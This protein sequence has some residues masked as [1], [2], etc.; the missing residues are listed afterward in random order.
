MKLKV[1]LSFVLAGALLLTAVPSAGASSN[2]A[3]EDLSKTGTTYE[4]IDVHILF[5][6]TK[7]GLMPGLKTLR[8]K[9]RN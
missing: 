9:S 4:Y 1:F 5:S 6:S 2:T 3:G 7:E 8:K